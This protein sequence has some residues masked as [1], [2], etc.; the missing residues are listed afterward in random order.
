MF[1]PAILYLVLGFASQ[2]A[3][4]TLKQEEDF[5]KALRDLRG[6]DVLA[7]FA[8]PVSIVML[9]VL[10]AL[11]FGFAKPWARASR[12]WKK[13]AAKAVMGATH[14]LIQIVLF[15]FVALIVVDRAAALAH[16]SA[17]FALNAVLLGLAGAVIG[18]LALGLYLALWCLPGGA[19][20]T[21]GNEAFSA[22]SYGWYKNF[23]RMR[24]G[25]DGDLTIYPIGLD[26]ANTKWELDPNAATKDASWIRPRS[27]ELGARL[28]EP[29]I[30]VRGRP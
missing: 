20:G 6:S 16:G 13:L 23:L 4:R 17:F 14:L 26:R 24:I 2:F 19:R 15:I 5:D 3:I 30:V 12:G 7:T 10:G 22:V 25:A 21:H 29:P 9:L 28:I 27:G 8:H 1:I 18:S 11:L